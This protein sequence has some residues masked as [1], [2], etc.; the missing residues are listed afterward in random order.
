M[1]IYNWMVEEGLDVTATGKCM[2]KFDIKFE[3]G[4]YPNVKID[5][6]IKPFLEGLTSTE[7]IRLK[8]LC[9][10]RLECLKK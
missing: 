5:L 8:A 2:T 9:D 1:S 7:I 3:V 6:C 10:V 4:Q